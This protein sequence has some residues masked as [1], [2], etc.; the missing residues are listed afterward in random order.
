MV[1]Q[2]STGGPELA[3]CTTKAR[4]EQTRKVLEKDEAELAPEEEGFNRTGLDDLLKRQSFY[5]YVDD[6]GMLS[7][8][9]VPVVCAVL[10]K[11]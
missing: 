5:T 11:V 3:V 2:R 4:L 6:G 9:M 10:G 7:K 1:V 8:I